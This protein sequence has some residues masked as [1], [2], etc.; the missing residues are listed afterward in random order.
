MEEKITIG[1][2]VKKWGLIYG[3][4][5]L[6]LAILTAIFD[7]ATKGFAISGMVTLASVA[8]VFGIYFLATKEYRESNDGLLSFGEGFKIV[9]LIGLLGGVIRAVGNYLYIKFIDTGYLDRTLE[10]QIEAQEKMG[11]PYDPDAIPAFVK[12][13][14]TAEFQ[15]ISSFLM[16]ILG[17]LIWGLIAVAINK[18]TEEY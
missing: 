6:I 2:S 3:L 1:D 18:K 16:A 13:M 12:M 17:F 15:I 14:Q 4:V 11:V 8:I 9:A 7:L 5:G 10:A